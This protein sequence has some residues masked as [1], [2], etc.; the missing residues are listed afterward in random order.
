VKA[1]RSENT[2]AK[3]ELLKLVNIKLVNSECLNKEVRKAVM[4]F[5]YCYFAESDFFSSSQEMILKYICERNVELYRRQLIKYEEIVLEISGSR[6][7]NNS[8]FYQK[9]INC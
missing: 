1:P 7:T 2:K 6:K 3:N 4:G 9:S 5:Y 8:Q